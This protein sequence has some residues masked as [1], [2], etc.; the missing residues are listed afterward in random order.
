MCNV[1][2]KCKIRHVKVIIKEKSVNLYNFTLFLACAS[3]PKAL[4][5][6]FL[7]NIINILSKSYDPLYQLWQENKS[8][9]AKLE[10][11]LATHKQDLEKTQRKLVVYNQKVIY[12]P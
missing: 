5:S 7:D 12:F 6:K 3:K 4:Q 1:S 10:T 9:N 8:A 2:F 11:E